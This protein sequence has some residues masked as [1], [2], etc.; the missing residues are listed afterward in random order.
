MIP[1]S[2]PKRFSERLPRGPL[3]GLPKRFL[4]DCLRTFA[5]EGSRKPKITGRTSK[6]NGFDRTTVKKDK[7]NK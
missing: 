5:K 1:Q 4:N 2:L 6:T 7:K 3:E